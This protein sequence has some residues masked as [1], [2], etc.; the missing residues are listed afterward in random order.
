MNRVRVRVRKE[1]EIGLTIRENINQT[2]IGPTINFE[3]I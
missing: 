1:C 3:R 2:I